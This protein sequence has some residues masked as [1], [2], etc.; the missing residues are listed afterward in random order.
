MARWRPTVLWEPMHALEKI[1]QTSAGGDEGIHSW[2]CQQRRQGRLVQAT[3]WAGRWAMG[4]TRACVPSGVMASKRHNGLGRCSLEVQHAGHEAGKSPTACKRQSV[5]AVQGRQRLQRGVNAMIGRC[6][7]RFMSRAGGAARP[8]A[9]WRA[10]GV[11]R[12][13]R[14]PWERCLAAHWHAKP[15]SMQQPGRRVKECLGGVGRQP[16]NAGY[17]KGGGVQSKRFMQR[18]SGVRASWARQPCEQ[19]RRGKR[20]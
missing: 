16:R 11:L 14:V 3:C 10:N 18:R 6:A 5:S 4:Q 8:I 20:G 13:I 9:R 7:S 12:E 17:E 15:R 1:Q 19:S 2:E